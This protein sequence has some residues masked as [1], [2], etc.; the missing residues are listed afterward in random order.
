MHKL[1]Y[2]LG[3]VRLNVCS[4]NNYYLKQSL[5]QSYDKLD[6]LFDIAHANAEQLITNEEDRQFLQLQRE[7]RTG[8]I[9]PVINLPRRKSEQQNAGNAL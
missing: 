5:K 1:A 6:T 2:I 7:S 9:G 8:C 4:N 3:E